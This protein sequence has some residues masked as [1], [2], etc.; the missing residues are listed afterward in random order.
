VLARSEGNPLYAEELAA[1]GPETIPEQLSDLFLARL[2]ALPEGPRELA[3]F[4]SVDGTRLD[5]EALRELSGLDREQ[6]DGRLRELLDAHVLRSTGDAL[7][8]RHGLLREAVYD[9]LLPDERT[10]LHSG[11]AGILQARVDADPAPSLSLLSRLAFHWSAAHDLP[12]TLAV[13][14][15]AGMAAKAVG[16][17]EAVTHLER[18][19]SLWGR[20]PDAEAVA[21][22]AQA[23]L[24]VHL[25]EAVGDQG[26]KERQHLLTHEAIALLGP[27]PDPLLASHVYSTLGWCF[28]ST[29]DG[30]EAQE[31]LQRA[32]E[33]AGDRPTEELS[34]A[35]NAQS[36]YDLWHEAFTDSLA[37]AT[38]AIEVA[39]AAAYPEGEMYALRNRA[40]AL[41]ILGRFPDALDDW[42][43]AI[44]MARDE[45]RVGRAVYDCGNLAWTLLM[46]GSVER[47]LSVARH[48]LEE[49]RA[50]GLPVQAAMCGEQLASGLV[51]AGR[52]D[53][54]EE[55]VDA[56]P[57]LGLRAD[58]WRAV[59]AELMLARG[60][61]ESAAAAVREVVRRSPTDDHDALCRMRLAMMLD[62]RS[63]ALESAAWLLDRVDHGDSALRAASAARIG[64]HALAWVGSATGLPASHLRN[65]SMRQLD[66]ARRGLTSEWRATYY[67]VQLAL[68]EGY[69]ARFAGRP[70]VDEFRVAV[71]LAEV[72][73][74]FFALE[75]RLDLSQELLRHG[76]RDEGRELLVDCWSAARNMG[77]ADLE[78]HASRL[79]V[80]ARVPLPESAS[81]HGPV[82]RLTPRERE[83]LDRLATGAT[84]KMIANELVISEKTVSVHVSNL[85]AKLGV[86]NRGAAAALARSLLG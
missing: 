52:F 32:V 14:F 61:A 13:S 55:M 22:H 84:N 12:R 77:A 69:A 10:R 28:L 27:D 44:G 15:R 63:V 31:A 6:L 36:N 56:L 41:Q 83:V 5:I 60:D 23:E 58:R 54:A 17:A 4:A 76:S 29:E 66:R 50:V 1:A 78:R 2:D 73:G 57:Q 25:A 45:G 39:R 20:V 75:P 82:S 34:R 35:L 38:R 72:F 47:G 81:S 53:E 68:A 37:L 80:R 65:Q 74:D 42:E 7:A 48:G 79:A 59:R 85:L 46:G 49:G 71:R 21:G 67:G 18:A 9:D 86:E 24:V 64:F 3:R 43:T 33:Y 62:E 11:L 51:W 70:A 8:F 26:D 16:A 40:C 30:A 19:W